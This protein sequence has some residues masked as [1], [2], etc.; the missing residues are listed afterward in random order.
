MTPG[1]V[2]QKDKKVLQP[3]LPFPL[4]VTPADICQA[5]VLLQINEIEL[6]ICS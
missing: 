2:V 6:L 4:R 1:W 3:L 5:F